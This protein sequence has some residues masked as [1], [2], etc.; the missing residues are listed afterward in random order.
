[1]NKKQYKEML[2]DVCS[3]N[4]S[5]DND[6]ILKQFLLSAHPSPRL[7]MQMKCVDK[8]KKKLAKDR[9]KS[10]K[11]IEW[12]EAMEKWIEEGYAK[13]FADIYKEDLKYLDVYKKVMG[14]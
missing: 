4:C 2:D 7:L 8:Y 9:N 3:E 5:E 14:N 12:G 13:K 6:C 1:M 10:P 11:K